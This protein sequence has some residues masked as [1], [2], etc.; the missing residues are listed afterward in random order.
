MP[1]LMINIVMMVMR[2]VMVIMTMMVTFLSQK[3]R[4]GLTDY[5]S[6]QSRA[7]SG[8]RGWADDGEEE[9]DEVEIMM[10]LM[11]IYML[12]MMMLVMMMLVMMMLVMMMLVVMM[13]K[14]RGTR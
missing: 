6:L 4:K 12:V 10:M 3:V 8:F 5:Y 11:M 9:G 14:K 13:G 2:E 7:F 1:C